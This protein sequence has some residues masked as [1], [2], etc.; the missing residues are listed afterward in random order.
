[1]AIPKPKYKKNLQMNSSNKNL[2]LDKL[3][4]SLL[5]SGKNISNVNKDAVKAFLK[6]NG[7]SSSEIEES[8]KKL[9][10]EFYSQR[11]NTKK[12][13]DE[14]YNMEALE[15]KNTDAVDSSKC[16]KS[17]FSDIRKIT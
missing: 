2:L 8:I 3:V 12:S 5:A 4:D 9:E 7:M 13:V 10:K 17:I 14:I 15:V 1:M 16:R 6:S 11:P